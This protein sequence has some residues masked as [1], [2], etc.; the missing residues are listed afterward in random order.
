MSPS[1]VKP[2]ARVQAW[3]WATIRF[4][5]AVMPG[6]RRMFWKV[7]ATFASLE[8]RKSFSRSSATTASPSPPRDRASALAAQPHGTA[9]RLVEAGDAVEH[10]GLAGAVRTN[11]RGDLLAAGG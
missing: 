2:E 5:S 9:G 1:K 8:M 10:G 11:Q 7:R 3:C 6:N 4:S